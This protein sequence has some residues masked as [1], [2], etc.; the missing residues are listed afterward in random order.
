MRKIAVALAG[1]LAVTACSGPTAGPAPPPASYPPQTVSP[2]RPPGATPATQV[3]ASP[4]PRP[5]P[6]R[7]TVTP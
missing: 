2:S 4:A 1:L 3:T 5:V 6:P 7:V